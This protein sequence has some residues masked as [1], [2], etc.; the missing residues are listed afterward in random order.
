[1][2]A[3]G[4]WFTDDDSALRLVLREG[5]VIPGDRGGRVRDI[6]FLEHIAD[7]P[8]QTRS[9]NERGELIYRVSFGPG[10]QAIVKSTLPGT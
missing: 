6:K 2:A 7:S 10:R 5:D 3:S 4:I 9:F 1:M 8:T